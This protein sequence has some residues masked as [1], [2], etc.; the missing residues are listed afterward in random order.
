MDSI[1]VT[2]IMLL[3][4]CFFGRVVPWSFAVTITLFLGRKQK[5]GLGLILVSVMGVIEDVTG[6]KPLG[7]G[8][9]FLVCLLGLVWLIER[10]YRGQW[11]WWYILGGGAEIL[12]RLAE[13][14]PIIWQS[15][16]WQIIALWVIRWFVKRVSQP[17]GIY[18]ER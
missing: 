5:I 12:F 1:M 10:Q 6:V 14:K 3:A 7:L 18:V 11:M 4:Y 15:V 13:G 9:A 17:E 8:S 2:G 16:V